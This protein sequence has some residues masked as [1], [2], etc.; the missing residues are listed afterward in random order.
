MQ[1]ELTEDQRLGLERAG[2][3]LLNG[4]RVDVRAVVALACDLLVSGWDGRA[5]IDVA[6]LSPGYSPRDAEPRLLA[7]LAEHGIRLQL[8]ER[9]DRDAARRQDRLGRRFQ[10][11]H[12][13]WYWVFET[14]HLL[15]AY[16]RRV[17]RWGQAA[18]DSAAFVR[19]VERIPNS[20]VVCH[21]AV[22]PGIPPGQYTR[23]TKDGGCVIGIKRPNAEYLTGDSRHFGRLADRDYQQFLA[24]AQKKWD[25]PPWP[26]VDV[27]P[28]EDLSAWRWVR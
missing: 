19:W 15:D 10:C 26:D 27:P 4:D 25:L 1:P 2:V 20:P 23:R 28:V 21:I 17:D 6:A 14:P 11:F 18:A 22:A 24:M 12:S 13:A 8:D 3:A 5:T 16:E 9:T 7:M